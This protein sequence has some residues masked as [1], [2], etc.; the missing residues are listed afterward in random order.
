MMNND[1]H[2]R[3]LEQMYAVAPINA[4]YQPTMQVSSGVAEISMA[5]MPEFLHSGHGMHGSVYFK[6]LDDAAYF[7][8][9]SLE[10]TLFLV[11]VSFTTYIT[12]PVSSGTVK[13][14]GRVVNQNKTQFIAEAILYDEQAREIARGN[15]IFIRS[16][17]LL[18]D[19]L[20]YPDNL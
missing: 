2:F 14:L 11:T 1:E 16:K 17:G 13:A 6:M 7:A 9:N 20:G 18:R 10:D 8:A 15:G 5:V 4:I 3:R 12:R 19:A